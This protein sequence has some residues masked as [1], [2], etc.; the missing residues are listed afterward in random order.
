MKYRLK[1]LFVP[2]L[3]SLAALVAG[4]TFLHWVL[5][6][7][8]TVFPVK[9]YF[10][11]FVFPLIFSAAFIFF[12]LCP[13]LRILQIDSKN[14]T[15]WRDFYCFMLFI[16]LAVPTIILQ[17]YIT[18]LTGELTKIHSL[19][20]I[21]NC[22]PT[23]YYQPENYYIHVTNYIYS[24]KFEV[25]P[26][27]RNGI[28]YGWNM[29]LYFVVPIYENPTDTLSYNNIVGWLGYR[30]KEN[31]DYSGDREAEYSS[32]F[33]ESINKLKTIDLNNF[34]Y[35]EKIGK[36]EDDDG[37]Q[38]A[39]KTLPFYT[40]LNTT[41]VFKRIH[42]PF[43]QRNGNK[44]RWFAGSLITGIIL[45]LVL[46]CIP[47][48]NKKELKAINA[49]KPTPGKN[50]FLVLLKLHK[51]WP[52]TQ[53]LIYLNVLIFLI[54]FFG[55][56][57]FFNIQTKHLLAWGGNYAPFIKDGQ[58]WRLFTSIFLH[59]GVVH[60]LYNMIALWLAGMMLEKKT[61]TSK[62]IALYLITGVCASIVSVIWHGQRV[63]VGASGAIF[64]LFGVLLTLIF[65]KRYAP[66][67]SKDLLIFVLI[68]AGSSL[69]MGMLGNVDNSAHIGGLLSG[70][71]AGLFIFPSIPKAKNRLRRSSK[72]AKNKN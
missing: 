69:F 70:M 64:G 23:K 17:H 12:Y 39:L 30:F 4:Y 58:C 62:F 48:I 34:C 37:F 57:G 65:T 41:T 11:H 21:N 22:K 71:L 51:D 29:Y 54:M 10:Y 14:D 25:Y 50:E 52:A 49:G 3:V 6:I 20:E 16:Y 55:G 8:F 31:T 19:K 61:G 56:Y 18:T 43:E 53:I 42:T 47:K 7:Q 60:L 45:W 26:R 66:E 67:S 24:R 46:I 28:R 36:S 15:K 44:L 33:F 40:E 5:N 59:G 35:L 9:D 68:Y 72:A 2:Y 32:F 63:S 13:R 27:D 38:E 1:I